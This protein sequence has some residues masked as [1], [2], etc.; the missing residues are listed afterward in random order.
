MAACQRNIIYVARWPKNEPKTLQWLLRWVLFEPNSGC[1]MF[2]GTLN[3]GGYGS[4]KLDDRA[5]SAHRAA[6]VLSGRTIADGYDLDHKCRVRSCCNPDHLEPVTRSINLTRG[7]GPKM[8][9][10]RNTTKTHCP[11]GHPYEGANLY[12]CPRGH[13]DC[14]T[15]Q[16]ERVRQ[17]RA[18]AR[19]RSTQ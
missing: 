16:R 14:I 4:I 8:L 7:I 2:G 12:I 13:R 15:C 19:Q 5:R 3:P 18:R 6:W 10:D 11:R 1:W 17:W 9:G